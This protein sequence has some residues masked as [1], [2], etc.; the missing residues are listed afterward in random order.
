MLLSVQTTIC[1]EPLPEVA[2][3]SMLHMAFLL[4]VCVSSSERAYIYTVGVARA[5]RHVHAPCYLLVNCLSL[6]PIRSRIQ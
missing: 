1:A 3:I 5:N 6:Y 2:S 4:A